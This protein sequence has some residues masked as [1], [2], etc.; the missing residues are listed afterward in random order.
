M[1]NGETI[2]YEGLGGG[3]ML[4]AKAYS[5]YTFIDRRDGGFRD[6][7]FPEACRQQ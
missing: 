2:G 3:E 4:H 5:F 1:P 6:R 7:G